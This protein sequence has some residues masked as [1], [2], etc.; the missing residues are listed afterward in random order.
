MN[1][2]TTADKNIAIGWGALASNT[3]G[4]QNMAIGVSAMSNSTTSSYNFAIGHYAMQDLTTGTAN[5]AFGYQAAANITTGNRNIAI[6]KNALYTGTVTHDNV[7]IGEQAGYSLTDGNAYYNV[8]IGS[9]ALDA[10]ST[11]HSNVAIGY[12]AASQVQTG[13]ANVAI[14]TWAML[15]ATGDANSNVV[16]GHTAAYDI[17]T[18]TNNVC[19]GTAAGYSAGNDLTDGDFCIYL[20]AFTQASSGSVQKEHVMGYNIIGK[21]SRTFY[22]NSDLGVYHGGNTSTWSTTS[23][24]RVKKNIVDNTTGL[25]K[26]NQ[27]Q[28]KNFEYKTEDE[29]KTDSPELTDVVKSAVVE[30]EGTQLGV[31]AQE[32]E[33]I[34]PDCVTTMSTGVKSVDAD[35]LTWYMINSIKELKKEND[36][37]KARITTLEG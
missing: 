22:N 21:G 26:I 1:A 29:I 32:L 13:N 9:Y 5:Y 12:A 7:I 37:L 19:I 14:G 23:D 10:G 28:V 20:G 30:K 18:G 24:I 33:T 27:I 3:T 31:I 11:S 4:V 16:I 2:N 15:G 8:A 34:I 36:A 17:T 25:D 35:N 6:G